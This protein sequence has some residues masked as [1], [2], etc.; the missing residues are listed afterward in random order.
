MWIIA[1]IVIGEDEE[2]GDDGGRCLR[3]LNE[4]LSDEALSLFSSP[5]HGSLQAASS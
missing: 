1:V 5:L 3:P 2:N 4:G